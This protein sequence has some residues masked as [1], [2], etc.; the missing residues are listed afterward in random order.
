[1]SHATLLLNSTYEPLSV[2]SWKKAVSLWFTEKVEVLE[3]YNDFNLRSMTLEIKC[4]AVVRLLTYVRVKDRRTKFSRINVFRRDHF[5]C[6]YCG[7][8]PGTSNLTFDHVV[9]KS[10]GGK[11]TWENITTACFPCNGRKGNKTL[12]NS[13]LT[14]HTIPYR[15]KDSD[16]FKFHF[17]FPKTPEAWR[18]YIYWT[19]E[20]DNDND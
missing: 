9:P 15:P 6:S 10:L 8:R 13:G 7:A 3:E 14:L 12:K 20:L 11:T 5:T 1:M 4:P 16:R 17:A 19:S 2:I 18:D